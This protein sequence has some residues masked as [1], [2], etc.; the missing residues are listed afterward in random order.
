MGPILS[1]MPTYRERQNLYI[2]N[3]IFI[4]RIKVPWNLKKLSAIDSAPKI[5]KSGK[6][7]NRNKHPSSAFSLFLV[8][9]HWS[10]VALQCC[11]SL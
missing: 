9:F 7:L 5:A 3:H 10:I 4:V 1:N 11:V 8:N 6:E 2:K